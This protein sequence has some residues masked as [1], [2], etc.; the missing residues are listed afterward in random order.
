MPANVPRSIE[1]PPCSLPHVRALTAVQRKA[2]HAACRRWRGP[3][4]RWR[5]PHS[6]LP[7][8]EGAAISVGTKRL[9]IKFAA[10]ARARGR[11]RNNTHLQS[12][13]VRQERGL[14]LRSRRPST[15]WHL[16]REPASVI[17]RLAAQAPIRSGR[18]SS[19]V[20]PLVHAIMSFDIIV[21][22]PKPDEGLV[23]DLLAVQD[24]FP[25]GTPEEIR[26][27]CDRV[28]PGI[29][30]SSNTGVYEAKEGFAVE[31]SIPDETHP[32]SLH[33][34]LYFGSSWETTGSAAFDRAVRRLYESLHWQSF[35]VSNNSSLL[36]GEPE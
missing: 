14:T 24:A 13:A 34:S 7:L 22:R 25:L 8:Q 26:R 6:T 4:V 32:S 36:L 23:A 19:N 29:A 15:A 18:L 27:Q 10:A 5:A 28:I 21:L 17:I 9:A 33:L 31:F 30:W 1:H 20:R 12:R 3:P 35:A 2:Q 16:G 11:K